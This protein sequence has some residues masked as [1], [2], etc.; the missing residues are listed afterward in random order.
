M[1]IY[2]FLKEAA[3]DQADIDRMVAA[4]EAALTLLRLAD[5][6]DPI[7]ELVARKVIEIARSGESDSAQIC[8]RAL[9]ELG[10]SLPD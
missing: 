1:P 6:S 5:R 10:I 7:C 8:A 9:K 3:F 4:Y 2:R